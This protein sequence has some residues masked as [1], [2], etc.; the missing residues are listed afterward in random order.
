MFKLIKKMKIPKLFKLITILSTLFCCSCFNSGTHKFEEVLEIK[1]HKKNVWSVAFSSDGK[2]LASGSSDK[3][4]KLWGVKSGSLIKTLEGHKKSVYSV[5]YHPKETLLASGSFDDTIK[6]WDLD[7]GKEMKTLKHHILSVNKVVFS[8]NGEYLVSTGD[9]NAVKIWQ[10]RIGKT[11]SIPLT[12]SG[13]RVRVK[14]V[15][16]SRKNNIIATGATDK[17][18]KLWDISNG[19]GAKP[20]GE[21]LGHKGAIN[22]LQFSPVNDNILASGS[23]DK[24]IMIWDIESKKEILKIKAHAWNVNSLDFHPDGKI[25][26]SGSTDKKIKLWDPKSGELLG[27]VKGHSRPVQSVRFSPDGKLL[28]SAGSDNTIRL[29]KIIKKEK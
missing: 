16:I 22:V 26:A 9:D 21:L 8:L 17:K 10:P 12:H 25:L 23:S 11:I 13:K 7:T 5:D 24:S 2:T 29:W 15:A 27:S 4:V 20:L 28:A 3:T 18:I 19:R 14:A 6:L 1:G